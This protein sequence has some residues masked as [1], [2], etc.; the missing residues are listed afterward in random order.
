M[1][2]DHI[3]RQY[4]LAVSVRHRLLRVG[5]FLSHLGLYFLDQPCPAFFSVFL[6]SV[7]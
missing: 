7:C 6:G 2:S 3:F 1:T 5:F 4:Y